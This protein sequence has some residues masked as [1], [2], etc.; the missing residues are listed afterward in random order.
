MS[1]RR[2]SPRDL[3]R[4]DVSVAVLDRW[5]EH[6]SI[7]RAV[8]QVVKAADSDRFL[9]FSGRDTLQDTTWT[10]AALILDVERVRVEFGALSAAADPSVVDAGIYTAI[11]RTDPAMVTLAQAFEDVHL[12]V[13]R[14][15]Q[16][17]AEQAEEDERVQQLRRRGPEGRRG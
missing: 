16:R 1:Y 2:R 9:A 13:V 17:L 14:K 6:A 12:M 4:S 15:A 10:L 8:E 3:L 7:C 11:L 5:S